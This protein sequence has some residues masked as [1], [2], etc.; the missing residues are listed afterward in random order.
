MTYNCT[1]LNF[2]LHGARIANKY[3]LSL[4]LLFNIYPLM[5][6]NNLQLCLLTEQIFH[7]F[8]PDQDQ[9]YCSFALL[10][11]PPPAPSTWAPLTFFS[12]PPAVTHYQDGDNNRDHEDEDKGNEMKLMIGHCCD[13]NEDDA[14]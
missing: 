6:L 9:Y 14:R 10:I 8:L 13:D 3:F 12:G 5:N 1:Y 4:D 7:F 2:Y 11:E